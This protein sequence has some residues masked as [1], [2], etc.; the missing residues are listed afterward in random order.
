MVGD[1]VIGLHAAD[2]LF[3]LRP[4]ACIVEIPDKLDLGVIRLRPGIA[5]E[6]LRD[7]HRRDLFELLRKLDRRIV[8]PAGEEMRKGEFAHLR[9]GGLYQFLVAVAER[10]VHHSPAMPSM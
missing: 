4:T 6:Q 10:R 5:E 2:D 9:G 1:A 3:L 7:R 8:A